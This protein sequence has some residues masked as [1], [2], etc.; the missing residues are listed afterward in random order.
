MKPDWVVDPQ[1][2]H[3]RRDNLLFRAFA[4]LLRLL[5]VLAVVSWVVIAYVLL[6][7]TR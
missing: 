6:G 7:V 5:I 4:I 1:A 3:F 2:P